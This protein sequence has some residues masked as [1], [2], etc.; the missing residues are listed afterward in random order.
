MD[1]KTPHLLPLS[2]SAA[3][4][5]QIRDDVWLVCGW[6]L[7]NAFSIVFATAVGHYIHLS[8]SQSSFILPCIELTAAEEAWLT[9]LG[10]GML[11]CAPSEAAA[12]ALALLLPCLRRRARRAL[13]YL[14]L[15]VTV[16]FHCM[17]VGAVCIFLAAD[18]GY[19]FGRIYYTVIFCVIVVCD[20]L[21]FRA[22]LGGNGW[23]MHYVDQLM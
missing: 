8:C 20:L 15:A 21:C 14:A 13:A 11:C 2:L 7:I 18:P 22:L 4:K 17:Y 1:G 5:K 19:I 6:A 10:I 23:G 3:T 9:A 16:L 12:A